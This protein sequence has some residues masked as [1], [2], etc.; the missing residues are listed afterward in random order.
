MTD[1]VTY[2]STNEIHLIGPAFHGLQIFRVCSTKMFLLLGVLTFCMAMSL[3]VE[4]RGA[5]TSLIACAW[6]VTRG[7][8]DSA[9]RLAAREICSYTGDNIRFLLVHVA[10]LCGV[11][12]SMS[13]LMYSVFESTFMC[14]AVWCLG[15]GA[16]ICR[17]WYIVQRRPCPLYARPP[18]ASPSVR[19][20]RPRD[21]VPPPCDQSADTDRSA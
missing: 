18:R 2:S 20:P 19:M 12:Y 17:V 13:S 9:T 1:S 16:M 7:V 11:M 15:W 14:R 21:T 10:Y 4:L 8:F 5:V 3:N 6:A